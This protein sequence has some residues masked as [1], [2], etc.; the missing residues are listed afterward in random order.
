MNRPMADRIETSVDEEKSDENSVESSEKCI[1]DLN[2]E[3]MVDD[4]GEKTDNDS[5]TSLKEGKSTERSSVR[6]Y[7]RSKSP[8]LRWTRELHLAFVHAVERLGGQESKPCLTSLQVHILIKVTTHVFSMIETYS[9][10]LK[11]RPL[12]NL[13]H[14]IG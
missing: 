1:F 11:K 14:T 9:S 13:K 10:P 7:V 2:E 5:S 4:N 12:V 8:R 6:Q 3:A